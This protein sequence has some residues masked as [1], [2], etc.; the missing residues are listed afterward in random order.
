MFGVHLVKMVYAGYAYEYSLSKISQYTYGTHEIY[1]GI[2]LGLVGVGG[3]GRSTGKNYERTL[4]MRRLLT[5][6]ILP[7]VLHAQIPT[8]GMVAKYLFSGN[9]N[10][11]SGNNING[12]VFGP[13]LTLDRCS[14]PNSAYHF[15]GNYQYISL[16][17][18]NSF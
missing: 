12:M 1:L 5:L 18:R 11:E 13:T 15:N 9:A 14:N 17:P 8:N 6:A 2:N 7:N 3:I 10:D 16:P 4:I